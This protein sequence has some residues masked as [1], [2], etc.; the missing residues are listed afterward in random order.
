[1]VRRTASDAVWAHRRTKEPEM[2]TRPL[3]TTALATAALVLVGGGA[4]AA[5]HSV[6]TTPDPQVVIPSSVSTSRHGSDDP[7]THDATDD[8][9]GSRATTTNGS[10]DPV[11]HDATDDKG[12]SRATTT[13]G[14]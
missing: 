8:K 4:L 9:G 1:M 3:M 13:N 12:G 7:V 11:S 10:D 14:R 6:S 2:R 5:A